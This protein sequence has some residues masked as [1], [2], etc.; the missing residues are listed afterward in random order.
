MLLRA[1]FLWTALVAAPVNA[2]IAAASAGEERQDVSA[3]DHAGI[4]DDQ[5]LGTIVGREN[6][7]LQIASANQRNTVSNNSV[8]GNSVTGTVAIDGNAFQNLQGLAVINANSGNNVAI[9]SAMNVT[10]NLAPMR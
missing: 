8:T 3:F 5:A 4:V 10:I 1:A 6:L 2:Q 9:N 7:G